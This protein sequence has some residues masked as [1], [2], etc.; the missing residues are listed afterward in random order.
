[1]IDI[2]MRTRIYYANAKNWPITILSLVDVSL[3]Q[4]VKKTNEIATD[5]E[6]DFD[7]SFLLNQ[8]FFGT[9]DKFPKPFSGY[10][11]FHDLFKIV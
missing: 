9:L 4:L 3:M 1:M 10:F 7:K 5:Y 2:T 6:S 8:G 11:Q